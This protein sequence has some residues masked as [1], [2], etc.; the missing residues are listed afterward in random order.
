ME[1]AL[2]KITDLNGYREERL[3]RFKQKD[4]IEISMFD[5]EEISYQ[6]ILEGLQVCAQDKEMWEKLR[7]D[8]L[9]YDPKT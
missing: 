5:L 1:T 4:I 3:D 8:C 9:D 7:Q 2:E 6:G